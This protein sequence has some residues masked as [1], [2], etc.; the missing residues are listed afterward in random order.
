MRLSGAVWLEKADRFFVPQRQMYSKNVLRP[1]DRAG[2][3]R[4][5]FA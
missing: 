1:T 5:H 2:R 4:P 3:R